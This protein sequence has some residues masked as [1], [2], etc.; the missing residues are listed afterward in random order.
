M[1]MNQMNI[2]KVLKMVAAP[3]ALSVFLVG[4]S[5]SGDDS[6]TVAK[7]EDKEITEAELNRLLQSQYGQSVL[8]S[9]ITNKIV[10]LEAEKL[11]ITVTDEE[12]AEEYNKYAE[13]Y[14]GEEALLSAIE[15]YNMTKEDINKDIEIYL[16]TLK[17][18]EEDIGITDEDVKTYFEEHKESFGTAEQVE[19]SHILVEDEATAKEVLEKLNAGEDFAKLAKEYSTDTGSAEDG[20]ALGFFGRGEM[21]AEFEEAAFAM[22]VGDVSKEPV[23]TEHG[24][25]IIKVTDKTEAKE[26]DFETSK[27]EARDMLIEERVNEQYSTWVSGKMEEYK[28]ET[29]LFDTKK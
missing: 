19:A 22:N 25:H 9:L 7:V 1:K 2:K 28:I 17:V 16:L 13:S 5:D 18:M 8:D 24:Y 23:K 20:G 14:G 15:S 26:P 6:R 3:L 12:I 21:V 29:F 11:E 27:E 10:E 4:C